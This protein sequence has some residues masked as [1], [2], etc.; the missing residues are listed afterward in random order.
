MSAVSDHTFNWGE[1]VYSILSV[2]FFLFNCLKFAFILLFPL[3]YLFCLANA[4]GNSFLVSV[5]VRVVVLWSLHV[6]V[7]VDQT[8]GQMDATFFFPKRNAD[9]QKKKPTSYY[10]IDIVVC[11]WILSLKLRWRF[12][13][14][15]FNFLFVFFIVKV[16]GQGAE[17]R[18]STYFWGQWD[19]G[20]AGQGEFLGPAVQNVLSE[21]WALLEP[22]TTKLKPYNPSLHSMPP[23]RSFPNKTKKC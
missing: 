13:V 17:K 5:C 10:W 4:E 22:T 16:K 11:F 14:S 9:I 12:P 6:Y 2:V 1:K 18:W 15:H 3:R 19:R 20:T 23:D 21:Y 7:S 8:R